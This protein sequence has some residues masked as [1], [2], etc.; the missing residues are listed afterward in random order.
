MKK[1]KTAVIGCGVVSEVYMTNLKS[2]FRVID[3]VACSD[4]DTARMKERAEQFQI[5]AMTSEEIFADPEIELVVNL[6]NPI[7]HYAVTKAALLA[8]KHVYSEKML[9]VTLKQAEELCELADSK[10]LRLGVAPDTFL[11]ATVQT[12]IEMIQRG[13][14]G[15]PLSFVASVTRD[16]G[17]TS[18]VLPHLRKLGAGILFD[19]G[20]YYMTALASIFGPAEKVFSFAGIHEPVRRDRRISNRT[21]GE[22]Y[23]V[24][25]ENVISANI[26]YRNGVMGTFHLNSDTVFDETRILKIYGTEGILSIGD[27]N[28]FAS[29]LILETSFNAMTEL[30]LLHGFQNECRG[31][32]VAE[33]AWAILE[34]RPHRAS[35]EMGYHLLEMLEGMLLSNQSDTAY[36]LQSDFDTPAP[37]PCGYVGK[38]EYGIWVPTEETA[39]V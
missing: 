15:K 6:T 8:G 5:K 27:P 11:G 18:E 25:T 20:C 16:F 1:I 12:A 30:P 38:P 33:M 10:H 35:K 29:S 32:A 28:V 14:I 36:L 9:A 22:Q 2:R 23:Q 34:Q 7:A 4:L 39:L 37:L 17:I 26:R 31:V 24:E 19:V 13:M 3:L 21:Y